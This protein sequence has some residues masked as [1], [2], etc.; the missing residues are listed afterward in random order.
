MTTRTEIKF[1]L[2]GLEDIKAKVGKSLRARVGVL[3]AN[4]ARTDGA[5]NNAELMLIQM[6]GSITRKIPPRDPLLAP[7]I[8]H[9]R[10]L[11]QKLRSGAM[12]QAFARGDYTQMLQLLGAEA[13]AIVLNAFETSGDGTWQPNAPSTIAAKGSSKPLIDHGYMRKSVTNDVVKQSG[14][15]SLSIHS[16][17]AP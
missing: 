2:D 4:A 8:K 1:N 15:Q 14:G 3:G 16:A 5:L 9:R 17:G 10:E 6:F 11:M 7:I 12:R 13:R